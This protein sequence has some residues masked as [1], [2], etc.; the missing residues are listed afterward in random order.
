MKKIKLSRAFRKGS[1][2]LILTIVVIVAVILVNVAVSAVASRYPFSLDLTSNQDY[3]VTLSDE[4]EAFVKGIQMPVDV[5]VCAAE[6]D[7]TGG[8]YANN[9][10]QTLYLL[11]YMQG[12]T[13]TV[14]KYARQV[15]SFLKNLATKNANVRL[16]FA[17]PNSVTDFAAVANKYSQDQLAYGDIIIACT[18]PADDG[19][20]F[21]RYQILKMKD[22]F[23]TESD[24]EAYYNG[25]TYYNKITGSS[26]ASGVISSLYIV[27]SE[28]SVQVAVLGGHGT[29][30]TYTQQL[31][32]FLRKNNYS[33]TQV[34]NL[35]TDKI[36][37]DA[38]F[39]VI[40]APQTDYST[41]EVKLLEQFLT[42]NGQ[43]GRTLVYLPT[44]AQ[45]VLPNLE[46]FLT[47]WGI[48]ILPAIAYDDTE[49]NYY[50]YPYLLF[51]QPAETDYTKDFDPAVQYFY[52]MPY[53]LAKAAFETNGSYTTKAILTTGDNACGYPIDE[54]QTEN[55][56]KD[57]AVYTGKFD[58][59]L[60]GTYQNITSGTTVSGES[61]VLMIGGDLFTYS[62][63]LTTSAC[64]N[65]TL[66][67]N[68]FNGLSGQESS[69][70]VT[71]EDKV[72]STTS[73]SEKILNTN[74]GTV[75]TVVFVIVLPVALII[76][77]FI[78]WI[79]RKKK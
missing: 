20:T 5:T 65:S 38:T 44:S 21:D 7:F 43:Y 60:L 37:E 48:E 54:G 3:T 22:I 61:H 42:N 12:N 64:Y 55:W 19:T 34:K 30:D 27:T 47:E 67:L 77:S 56:T 1:L 31:T 79:K 36:P 69:P 78:I 71:I 32:S 49:G 45:P 50:Q 17:N 76:L 68:L 33:F 29:D 14:S 52:P 72:I 2:S 66:L 23:T 16:S 11:D 26:L 74:A 62:D 28:T 70:A 13:E 57:K 40:S 18:H 35:L 63:V 6:D 51:A 46:E 41:E 39:A 8:A 58:L 73:F 15:R 59:V 10:M 25:Y 24:Q 9:L 75:V 53:R 4:Y